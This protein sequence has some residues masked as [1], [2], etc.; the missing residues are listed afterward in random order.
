[1]AT[2]G[3]YGKEVPL[4]FPPPYKG[5]HGYFP[6]SP[7]LYASL[8]IMGKGVAKGRDLGVIDMRAIAPTLAGLLGTSLPDAEVKPLD[9]QPS[10]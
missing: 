7:A 4:R 6:T 9:V 3:F 2:G 1:M 8:L 10:R 5:M